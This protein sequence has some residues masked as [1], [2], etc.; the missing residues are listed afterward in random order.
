MFPSS[1]SHWEKS[2]SLMIMQRNNYNSEVYICRIILAINEV[3]EDLKYNSR[4]DKEFNKRKLIY[5]N[6]R[7]DERG[8]NV[9]GIIMGYEHHK[10]YK[11]ALK[12]NLNNWERESLTKKTKLKKR[13]D[14][15]S[16]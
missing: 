4:C 13:R 6:S 11:K 2:P 1:T 15:S 3:N 10:L 16:W 7:Y 9:Q 12:G 8:K 14:F 5:L